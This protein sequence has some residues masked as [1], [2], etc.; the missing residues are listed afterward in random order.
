[1]R[2]CVPREERLEILT[3]CHSAE[4]SGNYSHIRTQEKVWSSGFYWPE[5]HEDIKRYVASCPKTK[6]P[7]TSLKE[8][9]CH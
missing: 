1:M 6:E 8:I 7:E 2:R 5:M 4:Y 3:K 9:L